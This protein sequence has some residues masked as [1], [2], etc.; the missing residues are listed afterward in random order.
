MNAAKTEI[1]AALAQKKIYREV[2]IEFSPE[3]ATGNALTKKED[4]KKYIDFESEQFAFLIQ[5]IR[6]AIESGATVIN[7]PDTLGNFLPH[8]TEEF[9]RKISEKTADLREQY[10]FEFSA[11]IHNDAASATQNAIAAIRGGATQIEVTI[12][13]I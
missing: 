3:D 13:G 5:V 7:V 4:G 6:M 12:G 9:F 10:R 2:E 11:H 1:G 8:E